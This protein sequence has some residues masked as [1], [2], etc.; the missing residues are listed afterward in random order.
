DRC[1]HFGRIENLVSIG[2][3]TQLDNLYEYSHTGSSQFV[4]IDEQGVVSFWI[5]SEASQTYDDDIALNLGSH[6]RLICSKVLNVL[7]HAQSLPSELDLGI[8]FHAIA[9]C[10]GQ[11]DTFLVGGKSCSLHKV[12]R[13]ANL[14]PPLEFTQGA[15]PYFDPSARVTCIT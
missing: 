7:N 14:S 5:T 9:V 12:S 13:F 4:A 8:N 15:Q 1:V 11:S 10:H 3:Q 2:N 6:V